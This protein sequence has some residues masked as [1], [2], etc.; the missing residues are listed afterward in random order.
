MKSL[1][2]AFTVSVAF[3]LSSLADPPPISSETQKT[4]P[5][6]RPSSHHQPGLMSWNDTFLAAR[7]FLGRLPAAMPG[8]EADTPERI[9]LGQMLYF[10]RGISIN[11]SQSCHD[12]HLLTQ[13]RSGADVTPTSKG[14]KGSFGK[15][16]S[17]TVINAGF[18]QAQFWM[19][20]L[21]ISRTRPKVPSSILSRWP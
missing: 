13:G 17:P 16:N 10:E 7:I 4:I 8:S 1:F 12:C 5:A 9:T 3:I 21:R 18:Q 14:A 20:V 2:F 11:N 19:D 15:R 6:S